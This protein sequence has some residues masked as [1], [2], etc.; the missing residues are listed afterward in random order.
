MTII[1]DDF[2][3][4]DSSTS[5]GT[6]WTNFTTGSGFGFHANALGIS[7]N[8]G[9]NSLTSLPNK[10]GACWNVTTFAG[11][12]QAQIDLSTLAT[13][14]MGVLLR[15][16]NLNSGTSKC[17][18]AMMQ[19]NGS[20][21]IGR[22]D[23][24][25]SNTP[26]LASGTSTVP[27]A[28]DKLCG[29]CFTDGSGNVVIEL[30]L[31]HSS[32]W[33]LVATYTD[34]SVNKITADGYAGIIWGNNTASTGRF[35]NFAASSMVDSAVPNS[36]TSPNSIESVDYV[37]SANISSTTVVN[38]IEG[39]NSNDYA[40]SQTISIVTRLTTVE[41]FGYPDS[42]TISSKSNITDVDIVTYIEVVVVK[43]ITSPDVFLE[44]PTSTDATITLSGSTIVGGVITASVDVVVTGGTT[45]GTGGGTIVTNPDDPGYTVTYSPSG[46]WG[47]SDTDNGNITDIS[48]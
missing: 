15:A 43:G 11:A 3:R 32:A 10:V 47:S 12:V 31:F 13:D 7:S 6:N 4:A 25:S 36:A 28:G 29:V 42:S 34:T 39:Y 8:K 20:Y 48:F 18:Y 26:T 37:E 27:A 2:T 38:S 24:G 45:G 21:E 17:Y 33:S 30:W 19:A 46:D 14:W 44:I 5:L 9:Y 40:D 16:A 35:D 22:M 41:A 23:S 1:L